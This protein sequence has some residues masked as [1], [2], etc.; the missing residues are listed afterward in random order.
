MESCCDLFL[1]VCR[2]WDE[3][4]THLCDLAGVLTFVRIFSLMFGHFTDFLTNGLYAE[5]GLTP[6]SPA[7]APTTGGGYPGSG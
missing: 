3:S 1:K 5:G 2:S 6:P 7:L 4:A